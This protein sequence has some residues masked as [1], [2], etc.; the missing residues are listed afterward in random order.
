MID[1]TENVNKHFE[2]LENKVNL[3]LEQQEA[4]QRAVAYLKADL[5]AII[6]EIVT[7]VVNKHGSQGYSKIVLGGR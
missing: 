6:K 7:E 1:R 4:L 5:R 3:I 2:I